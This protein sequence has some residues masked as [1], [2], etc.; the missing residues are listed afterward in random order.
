MLPLLVLWVPP[1]AEVDA[2]MRVPQ[3]SPS[4][5]APW[6]LFKWHTPGCLLLGRNLSGTPLAAYALAA[7]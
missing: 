5:S 1:A 4:T 3:P 2:A 7:L 6:P